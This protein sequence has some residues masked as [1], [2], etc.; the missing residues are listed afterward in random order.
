MEGA[1]VA[2][3]PGTAA[4]APATA[5][6]ASNWRRLKVMT[7]KVLHPDDARVTAERTT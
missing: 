7:E 6:A 4:A 1:A 2:V 3:T 5:V